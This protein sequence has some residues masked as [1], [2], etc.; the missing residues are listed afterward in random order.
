MR[1][2]VYD[3]LSSLPGPREGRVWPRGDVRA[4]W[5]NA[6][7]GAKI[8]DFHFHDCRHHFI[9]DLCYIRSSSLWIWDKDGTIGPVSQ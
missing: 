4:A 7:E 3:T 2:A 9:N 5:E 6:V 1:R 8:D